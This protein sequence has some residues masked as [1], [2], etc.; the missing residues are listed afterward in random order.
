MNVQRF[1]YICTAIALVAAVGLTVREAAAT[2]AVISQSNGGSGLSI[3]Q[4]K[5]AECA[6]LPAL[7]SI[8]TI[9]IK[10]LGGWLSLSQDGPTGV[11]G[12]LI[13]LLSQ[14]RACTR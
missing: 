10:A 14:S 7:P 13:Y 6:S 9:F 11:D 12:G 3:D 1:I 2:S 8:R 5:K 4:V